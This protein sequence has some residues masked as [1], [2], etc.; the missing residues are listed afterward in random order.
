[1]QALIIE[2]EVA[3]ALALGDMLERLG[4]KV[5][6]AMSVREAVEIAASAAPDAVFTD[7]RLPDGDG[8]EAVAAIR[9]S[10]PRVPVVYVTASPVERDPAR[11]E[12]V[13]RK[14]FGFSDIAAAV[15]EVALEGPPARKTPRGQRSPRGTT[16]VT[17]QPQ[18]SQMQQGR[19]TSEDEDS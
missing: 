12:A 1:M 16:P 19:R 10:L 14:P 2:D 5:R 18:P 6:Y 15:A 4:F 9:S 8:R 11:R 3:I 7:L 13:V 17:T